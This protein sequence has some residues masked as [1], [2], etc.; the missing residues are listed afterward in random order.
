VT[1][2]LSGM[3]TATKKVARAARREIDRVD[4]RWASAA[5]PR[6]VTVTGEARSSTRRRRRSPA[7][8]ERAD[9]AR[10]GRPGIPR[11]DQAD[12]GRAVHAGPTRGPSSGSSGQD[13]VYKF[14]GV[15]VT[16]P[17]FGTLSAEP[18]SHDIAQ[19]T[20]IKGGAKAMDFIRAGGFAIDSVS[21]SGTSRYAGELSFQLQSHNMSAGSNNG[22]VA[23]RAEPQL[24]RRQRRR[25]VLKD[26]S[27]SSVVL[28]PARTARTASNAY[29]ELP[30]YESTRNEGFGKLTLTPTS[31][32]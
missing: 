26:R 2:T 25:P 19:V 14:D 13:N 23:L 27:S 11:P 1:F 3:Q 12:P 16:L 28:P 6:A 9:H 4:A 10:A 5:S 22:A 21:K 31:R 17:L 18:A 32:R 8:S 20:V 24:D 30:D 29:G 15:N 7:A